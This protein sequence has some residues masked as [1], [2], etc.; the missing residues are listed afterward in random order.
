MIDVLLNNAAYTP[1]Y[2]SSFRGIDGVD[3][4]A[5]RKSFEVNTI[6]T[7]KVIQAF[8]SNV[9]ESNNGKIINLS[10]KAA[11]FEER[12]EIP[13]MYSYAMSKAAMNS[14]VKTLSFETA[15]K[16]IIVIAIS[17]GT[18]NTTLGMG[19][20]GAIDIDESVSKMMVVIENLTMDENGLFLDYED[21]RVI[22]W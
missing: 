6:G 7:M 15:E 9:E 13:M 22:G 10:T 5:T 19:L 3:H 1:R 20:M 4:E 17:P 18:V 11:S 2:L 16:N 14:M 12:P 8:I 21:G